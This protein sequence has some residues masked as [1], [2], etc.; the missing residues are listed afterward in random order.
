MRWRKYTL[1]AD[2]FAQWSPDSAYVAGWI[3]GDGSVT[4]GRHAKVY[5]M[6]SL[7]ERG[8]LEEMA[9]RM[10]SNTPVKDYVKAS[11]SGLQVCSQRLV[12]GLTTS[13]FIKLNRRIEIPANL[14]LA[15]RCFVRGYFDAD[16]S[17][18]W[19]LS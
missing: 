16:G 13:G 7:D 10:G 5:L 4:Y 2:F 1:N 18:C 15:A 17:F 11:N 19:V 12:E 9:R 3:A 8:H 14:G 6:G